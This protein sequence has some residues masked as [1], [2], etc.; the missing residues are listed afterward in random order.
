[1][2][3]TCPNF[4]DV[5]KPCIAMQS[6]Y[7][8]KLYTNQTCNLSCNCLLQML[9][10][11]VHLET[12]TR[13]T[14]TIPKGGNYNVSEVR[15]SFQPSSVCT[16]G[17]GSTGSRDVALGCWPRTREIFLRVWLR[18]GSGFDSSRWSYNLQPFATALP[19]PPA[20]PLTLFT[21]TL[22][23]DCSGALAHAKV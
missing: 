10:F 16:R 18:L 3:R 2:Q 5:P 4:H 8:Q 6:C 14:R 19:T 1:M 12:T 9:I 20:H 7:L 23:K 21:R 22:E 17:S 13:A 15:E 11:G